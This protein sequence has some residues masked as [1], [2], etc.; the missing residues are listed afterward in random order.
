[1]PKNPTINIK[2]NPEIERQKEIAVRHTTRKQAG[3][4]A[5]VKNDDLWQLGMDIMDT[6]EGIKRQLDKKSPA[7]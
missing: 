3:K 5:Q 1:M 7:Q 6:L 2:P 4:P